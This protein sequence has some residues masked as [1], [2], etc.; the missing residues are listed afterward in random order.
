MML[1]ICVDDAICHQENQK[2]DMKSA[3]G[4]SAEDKHRKTYVVCT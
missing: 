3:V 2:H 1:Q 4:T